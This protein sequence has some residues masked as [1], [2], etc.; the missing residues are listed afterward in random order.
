MTI[1]IAISTSAAAQ[2]PTTGEMS[3]AMPTSCAFAQFTPSVI[4]C[5]GP[6]SALA[7]PTPII[8]PMSVCEL[9]AGS[10]SHQVPTFQTIAETRSEN[11][12]A[13]PAAEPTFRT[14]STGSS[15][16]IPNATAPE[17]VITPMKFQNPDQTTAGVG[18]SVFV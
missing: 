2:K 18:L 17:E 15:A 10:P 13:N 12:I 11:T 8:D 4:E 1:R 3:R 6:I 14:N 5:D 7:T 9:E 16:T